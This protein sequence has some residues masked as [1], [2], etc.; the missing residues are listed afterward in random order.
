[1]LRVLVSARSGVS[2]SFGECRR[3]AQWSIRAGSRN[4]PILLKAQVLLDRARFSPG[5]IDARSGEN[6]GKALR[7]LQQAHAPEPP[8]ASSTRQPGTNLSTHRM[9]RRC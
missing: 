7:A 6:F 5:V 1:M 4:G 2:D 3:D 8:A 9:T